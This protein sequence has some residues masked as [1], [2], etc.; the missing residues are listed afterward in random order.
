ML[1]NISDRT[2]A[3]NSWWQDIPHFPTTGGKAGLKPVTAHRV[4]SDDIPD[5]D[6]WS[7]KRARRRQEVSDAQ[8]LMWQSET[9]WRS[10]DLSTRSKRNPKRGG[11]RGS[12]GRAGASPVPWANDPSPAE[13]DS[14]ARVTAANTDTNRVGHP[15]EWTVVTREEGVDGPRSVR[16]AFDAAC[17]AKMKL[18]GTRWAARRTGAAPTAVLMS[19]HTE[20]SLRSTSCGHRPA[21]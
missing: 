17:K 16:F 14:L 1:L 20:W 5:D 10:R 21:G 9:F 12:S 13:E 3:A 7:E 4:L 2:Q 8:W 18:I 19:I 15:M 6:Y 11:L